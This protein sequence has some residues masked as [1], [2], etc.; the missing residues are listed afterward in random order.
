MPKIK[1]PKRGVCEGAVFRVYRTSTT[2]KNLQNHS[3]FQPQVTQ[4]IHGSGWK[5]VIFH[6]P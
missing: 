2:I 3:W 4:K 1:N 5:S 6:Q